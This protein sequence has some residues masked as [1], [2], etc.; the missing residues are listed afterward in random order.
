MTALTYAD[1]EAA[2]A[3]RNALDDLH[4][5]VPERLG[6]SGLEARELA[7]KIAGGT[8]L[9]AAEIANL[10]RD[11]RGIQPTAEQ[12]ETLARR[13]PIV[14]PQATLD[15][16]QELYGT[17]GVD[18]V[19]ARRRTRGCRRDRDRHAGRC[20]GVLR[21]ARH[22]GRRGGS[23]ATSTS[24]DPEAFEPA[25]R[26]GET[27]FGL[28]HLLSDHHAELLD[29]PGSD[30]KSTGEPNP[31]VTRGLAKAV[32]PY[33]ADMVGV[34]SEETGTHETGHWASGT[35]RCST[36]CCRATS[37]LPGIRPPRRRRRSR[38]WSRCGRHPM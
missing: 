37:T 5:L 4:A 8:E 31:A 16:V 24:G 18:G 19:G 28:S 34:P 33:L 22:D 2:R 12:L 32:A 30:G 6:T 3:I 13:E 35:R 7:V 23:R 11:L 14:V 20:G 38:R 26:A 29:V 21:Q 25:T 1:V 27:A 9:T 15:Y 17:L 10:L 36:Q